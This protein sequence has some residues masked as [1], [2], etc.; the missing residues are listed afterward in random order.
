MRN[1]IDEV[2]AI[3]ANEEYKVYGCF[4][5]NMEAFQ[6][7]YPLKFGEGYAYGDILRELRGALTS[8]ELYVL[9]YYV[10]RGLEE[11]MSEQ[12]VQIARQKYQEFKRDD[13]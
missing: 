7:T 11:L 13:K 3:L 9:K 12:Q 6:Q 5:D 2:V 4:K 8:K 10:D 1:E